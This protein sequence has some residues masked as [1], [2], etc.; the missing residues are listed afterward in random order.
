MSLQ[1]MYPS[2]KDENGKSVKCSCPGCRRVARHVHHH[3]PRCQ[4]GSDEPQNLVY[5]CQKC[6][7][8]H[9][10]AQGDFRHWGYIGGLITAQTMKSIPNLKQFQGEA[11]L[12][13]WIAYCE[14]KANAQMGL[15]G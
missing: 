8:A 5:L 3:V 12:V 13:R 6:H 14:R 11:G 2:L 4:G 10:S 15:N 9:H 1:Q 7:V